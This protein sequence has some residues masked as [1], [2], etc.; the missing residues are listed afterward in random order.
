MTFDN[1]VTKIGFR[2]AVVL[3]WQ[4]KRLPKDFWQKLTYR[5]AM[6]IYQNVARSGP[7]PLRKKI[8]Q[9][10][11][12]TALVIWQW[13][14]VY[15]SLSKK[16]KLGRGI[17]LGKMFVAAEES[18]TNRFAVWESMYSFCLRHRLEIEARKCFEQMR[19]YAEQ[20]DDWSKLLRIARDKQDKI[21]AGVAS[22]KL[23]ELTKKQC[24]SLEPN[25]WNGVRKW[26]ELHWIISSQ[27]RLQQEIEHRLN[28]LASKLVRNVQT[29]EGLMRLLVT[30]LSERNNC[31]GRGSMYPVLGPLLRSQ[32]CRK[33]VKFCHSFEEL[34]GFVSAGIPA[35]CGSHWTLPHVWENEDAGPLFKKMLQVAHSLDH[36]L[37]LRTLLAYERIRIAKNERV[38]LIRKLES[39]IPRLAHTFDDWKKVADSSNLSRRLLKE[40]RRQLVAIIK[41]E[42]TV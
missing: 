17:L 14:E 38:K 10:I 2:W 40:V 3:F 41:R 9:V 18:K 29:K 20:Y 12:A 5:E 42:V 36:H 24:C 35:G 6:E 15:T 39:R 8:F 22:A 16:D 27:P 19:Q 32:V 26:E 23:F 31:G 37:L 13:Q 34:D 11:E 4:A 7:S 28:V 33:I 21:L 1:V 30:A 25:D